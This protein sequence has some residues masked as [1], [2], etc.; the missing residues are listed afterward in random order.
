MP[1]VPCNLEEIFDEVVEKE[2]EEK[3]DWLQ[4]R[5]ISI[6]ASREPEMNDPYLTD[7][8]R[9]QI[10]LSIVE[11]L[12]VRKEQLMEQ[13]EEI[14]EKTLEEVVI[15]MTDFHGNKYMNR[16]IKNLNVPEKSDTSSHR[17]K[18]TN[19]DSNQFK[20][21]KKVKYNYEFGNNSKSYNKGKDKDMCY[22]DIFNMYINYKD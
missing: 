13:M 6:V 2:F 15:R 21:S 1:P 14:Y 4:D 19:M 17:K 16:L 8:E 11:E 7:Q 10:R 5:I 9:E 3:I 18:R 20:E 12:E 22:D